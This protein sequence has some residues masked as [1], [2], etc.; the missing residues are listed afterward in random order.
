MWKTPFSTVANL[1]EYSKH[2]CVTDSV[3]N[4][5]H[6]IFVFKM[7]TFSNEALTGLPIYVSD[8]LALGWFELIHIKHILLKAIAKTLDGQYVLDLQWYALY[9]LYNC[10]LMACFQFMSFHL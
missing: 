1:H 10:N 7:L 2:A 3:S 5:T 6:E 4:K 8:L 9:S